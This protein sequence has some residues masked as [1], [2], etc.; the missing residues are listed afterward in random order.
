[1]LYS[2]ALYVALR[3]VLPQSESSLNAHSHQKLND[4]SPLFDDISWLDHITFPRGALLGMGRYS[5]T[6]AIDLDIPLEKKYVLKLTGIY[7]GADPKGEG[8]ASTDA[9]KNN[10]IA[11]EVSSHLSPHAS[12]PEN[13]FFIENAPNLLRQNNTKLSLAL[14]D[15]IKR[16]VGPLRKRNLI[17]AK[18]NLLSSTNISIIA[19]ER[20]YPSQK[21]LKN[22]CLDIPK[23]KVRCFWRKLFE[24]FDYVHSRNVMFVDVSLNNF[25]IQ[26]GKIILFDLNLAE[27]FEANATQ[28]DWMVTTRNENFVYSYDI[29]K[30]G[31]LLEE[32][33]ACQMEDNLNMNISSRDL[34]LLQQM[35]KMMINDY[36]AHSLKWYIDHYEYFSIGRD[37]E[38]DL[39]W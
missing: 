32:Y 11:V 17:A 15:L 39:S 18:E 20:A 35:K 27:F 25:M 9:I 12:I 28:Y 29:W 4:Q 19:Q 38:C 21:I 30:L 1:M 8:N 22:N 16:T 13:L 24:A 31:V 23:N 7:S 3:I 10:L 14:N 5:Y 33:L 6:F 34:K 26:D 36:D 2:I 37:E